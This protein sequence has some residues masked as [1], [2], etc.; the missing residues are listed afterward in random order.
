MRICLRGWV[1]GNDFVIFFYFFRLVCNY[2]F[3]WSVGFLID[4]FFFFGLVV[5]FW[6]FV[7]FIYSIGDVSGEGV[8]FLVLF[9]FVFWRSR[10]SR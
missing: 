2:G 3:C 1:E 7:S 4:Y 5:D 10:L 9:Y 8:L 6:V